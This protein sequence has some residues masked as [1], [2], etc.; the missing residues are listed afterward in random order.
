MHAQ[1]SNAFF[2]HSIRHISCFLVCCLPTRAGYEEMCPRV[3]S[4]GPVAACVAFV[5]GILTRL[6]RLA[7]LPAAG[8]CEGDEG[9]LAS[10]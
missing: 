3:T 4:Q 5:G 2:V 1:F 8:R 6:G 9:F 10:S 7:K